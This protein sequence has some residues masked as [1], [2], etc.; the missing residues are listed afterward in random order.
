VS[1]LVYSRDPERRTVALTVDG[2]GLYTLHEGDAVGD[3]EVTRILADRVH[4]RHGDR[5]FVVRTRD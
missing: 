1:F 5:E 4:V 3:V 2:Q